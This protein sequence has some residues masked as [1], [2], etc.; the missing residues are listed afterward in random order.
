MWKYWWA[1][2]QLWYRTRPHEVEI[3]ASVNVAEGLT[4]SII[5]PN[6]TTPTP[7]NKQLLVD[8]RT[9]SFGSCGGYSHFSIGTC[10]GLLI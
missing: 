8:Q 4:R 2:V 1:L 7:K 6:R 9:N 5:R 10:C 3:H